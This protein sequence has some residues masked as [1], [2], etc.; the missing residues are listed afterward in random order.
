MVHD[1]TIRIILVAPVS[2]D[3]FAVFATFAR[4]ARNL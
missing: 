3:A 4:H 1:E 2:D